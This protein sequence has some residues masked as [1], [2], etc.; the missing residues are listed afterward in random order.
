[1]DTTLTVAPT[2]AVKVDRALPH[3]AV[4]GGENPHP[5]DGSVACLPEWA[6]TPEMGSYRGP[7]AY[8]AQRGQQPRKIRAQQWGNAHCVTPLLSA[9]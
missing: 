9:S 7:V 2:V 4:I 8:V 3:V 5:L 1:M 6:R